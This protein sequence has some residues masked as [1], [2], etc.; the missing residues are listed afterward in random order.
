[1]IVASAL[2]LV[3]A[4]VMYGVS[5]REMLPKVATLDAFPR[6]ICGWALDSEQAMEKAVFENLQPDDYLMRSYT[7]PSIAVPVSLY[8]AYYRTQRNGHIPHSPKNCLPGSGWTPETA[9]SAEIAV[10]GGET[11]RVNRYIVQKDENRALVLYW[12]QCWNRVDASEYAARMHLLL[13]AVKY[14][15]TDTALV[16]VT[17]PVIPNE[18]AAGEAAADFAKSVYRLMCRQL[19]PLNDARL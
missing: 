2:L 5:R 1:M 10:A 8:V 17:V 9:G 6:E 16:R 19:P 11:L 15:R 4:A 13:D 12:Y 3:Q 14:N 7:N 18:K